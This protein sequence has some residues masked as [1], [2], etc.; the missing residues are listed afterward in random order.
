MPGQASVVCE[1][2]RRGNP[3]SMRTP[4]R[5][6]EYEL[7][8]VMA[9]SNRVV[10]RQTVMI[11]P[12]QARLQATDSSEAGQGMDVSWIGPNGPNDFIAVASPGAAPGQYESRALSRAGAPATVFAPGAA[13]TY[14]LR[15]VWAEEDS[16]LTRRPLVVVAP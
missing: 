4:S 5:P 16:V 13:G 10:T 1:R 3:L 9:Q 14:E 2:T 8:Y 6:G 11:L 7:R 15:Y 12:L